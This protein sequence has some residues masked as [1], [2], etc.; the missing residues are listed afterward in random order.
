MSVAV[1]V[2]YAVE[3]AAI[4][5]EPHLHQ[6]AEAALA[7][8]ADGAELAIRVVEEAESR[9]L[10]H[11]YRGKDQP[12]NVLSFPFEAPP[13]LEEEMPHIGDLAICAAVVAREAA[14]Q[15]KAPD[16]HWAHM[17]IHGCLHL[18]GYD[19]IDEDEAETME[20][21]E[22]E[23]LAGLGYPNPYESGE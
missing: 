21:L 3:G 19:H 22:I 12:T 1:E 20:A 4:P 7:G 11:T 23:I 5:D 13:G 10:N 6:W 18:I 2:I 9:T 14:E 15:D 16:A 17:V 8:R